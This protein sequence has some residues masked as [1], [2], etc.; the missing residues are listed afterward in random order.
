MLGTKWLGFFR[1]QVAIQ[2]LGECRPYSGLQCK[3]IGV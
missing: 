2:K 3:N 1:C